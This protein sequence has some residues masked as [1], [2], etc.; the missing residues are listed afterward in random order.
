MANTILT[1]KELADNIF[2]SFEAKYG[3]DLPILK[4]A[5]FHVVSKVLAGLFIILYKYAGFLGLQMFVRYASANE[6]TINGQKITP[7]IETGR[8]IG[9]GDPKPAE[10]AKLQIAINVINQTGSLPASTQLIGAKNGVTYLTIGNVLLDAAIVNADIIAASDQAGGDGAGTIGNLDN[11]EIVSFISSQTNV[12][13]DATVSSTII[14]GV[15]GENVEVDYRQRVLN[16]RQNPPQGGALAD[17]V[18]WGTEVNGIINIYVYTGPPG[19]VHVYAEATPESSGNPDGIPT[20]AQLIEIDNSIQYDD[21]TGLAQRR[22]EGSFVKV[23]PI[24]RDAFDVIV[25]GLTDV[26]DIALVRDEITR[27]IEQYLLDRSPFVTGWSVLPRN[28]RITQSSV[29]GVVSDVV[30]SY[31]GIF[32]ALDLLLNSSEIQTYTLNEG[33]K[34]KLGT[35]DFVA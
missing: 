14:Q 24:A 19:E 4:K 26:D 6:T 23:F 18:I 13:Q 30:N 27:A 9:V 28:D 17:Y 35:I 8:D 7:L 16:Q 25:Y 32:A 11:G 22:P 12:E 15:D 31:G 33:Q 10:A 5:F 20:E 1:T 2:A 21:D 29:S 3:E 34:A